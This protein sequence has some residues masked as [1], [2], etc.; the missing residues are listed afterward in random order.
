MRRPSL[1]RCMKLKRD[2]GFTSA[3]AGLRLVPLTPAALLCD[4]PIVSVVRS[5]F[6]PRPR[7]LEVTPRTQLETIAGAFSLFTSSSHLQAE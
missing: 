5:G 7:Q 6:S 4:R 3:V 1:P 2:S